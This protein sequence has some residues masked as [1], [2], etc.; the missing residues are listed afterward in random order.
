MRVKILLMVG[1]LYKSIANYFEAK[2][3]QIAI[4]VCKI[5]VSKLKLD[6]H[7]Q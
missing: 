6:L 5:E 7:C 2:A 3:D 4:S 1:R